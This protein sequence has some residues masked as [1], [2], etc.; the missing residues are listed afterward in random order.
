MVLA[1]PHAT[2]P[3]PTALRK[4]PAPPPG[5]LAPAD[6]DDRRAI[7]EERVLP[8]AVTVVMGTIDEEANLRVLLPRL[9][10][11]VREIVVVDDGSRDGSREIAR[12]HGAIVIARPRRLG[13]GSAVYAAVARA[14]MPVVATMDA[15]V[16]HPPDVLVAA[17]ERLAG[18][19]DIVR[20][21]R[22]LPGSTW[23]A[24]ALR[25]AGLRL[26]GAALATVCRLPLTDPTNGFMLARRD[27]FDGPTRFRTDPGEGW[28][29]EFL[30]RNRGRT[31][32]ELPYAHA[33]RMSGRSHNTRRH[34][35]SRALRSLRLGLG[36]GRPPARS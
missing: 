21:S 12:A 32:I 25:R 18:G 26:Y 36:G 14:S 35:L 27:C 23:E 17:H 31:M 29:A 6:P 33:A 11:L 4:S 24:P 5:A 8:L 28:V 9:A 34:E 30:A 2:R 10:P 3:P 15:D 20:F 1:H 19:C 22:F 13:I 16:S 7:H